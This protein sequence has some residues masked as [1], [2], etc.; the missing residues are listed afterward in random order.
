MS[1]IDQGLLTL[2]SIVAGVALVVLLVAA[3]T[4]QEVG[5]VLDTASEAAVLTGHPLIGSALYCVEAFCPTG[6]P[7]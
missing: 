1:I 6:G 4:P 5:L 3:C 7:H 2:A